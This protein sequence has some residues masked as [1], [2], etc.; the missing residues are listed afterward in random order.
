MA[1]TTREP[2][3]PGRRLASVTHAMSYMDCSR[4]TIYR[5]IADRQIQ[6]FKV[7]RVLRVDLDSIDAA[8]KP[9]NG[10]LP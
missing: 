4:N 10:D 8:L 6:A 1:A 5:L 9:V 3:Q 7:G 2:D